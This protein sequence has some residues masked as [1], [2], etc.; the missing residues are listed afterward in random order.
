MCVRARVCVHVGGF[1][2]FC[3]VGVFQALINRHFI[4]LFSQESMHACMH[5]VVMVKTTAKETLKPMR[6]G[7]LVGTA[8]FS[9]LFCLNVLCPQRPRDCTSYQRP[10]VGGFCLLLSDGNGHQQLGL[11][12]HCTQGISAM[13]PVSCQPVRNYLT[14]LSC[15]TDHLHYLLL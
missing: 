13:Q 11:V 10:A 9:V 2:W 1:F 3:L 5:L 14:I 15:V 6:G 12:F 7:M 4:C 8:G